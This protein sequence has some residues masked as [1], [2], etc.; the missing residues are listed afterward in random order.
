MYPALSLDPKEEQQRVDLAIER[1][2][3]LHKRA[4]DSLHL[5]EMQTDLGHGQLRHSR[6][7]L[8][9]GRRVD[10]EAAGR[11]RWGEGE[12]VLAPMALPPSVPSMPLVSGHLEVPP[13]PIA[14]IPAVAPGRAGREGLL[15]S[16]DWAG[17]RVA[18][19][20]WEGRWLEGV[21][22]VVER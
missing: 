7:G 10:R 2:D 4:I 1:A 15:A 9:V 16:I 13:A 5:S 21:L 8:G 11:G 17:I 20:W 22:V 18:A 19:D 6:M 14:P 3:A 12:R